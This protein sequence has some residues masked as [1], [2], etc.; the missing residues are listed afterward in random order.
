VTTTFDQLSD[1]EMLDGLSGIAVYDM[2]HTASFLVPL[3]PEW[4]LPLM[5]DSEAFETLQTEICDTLQ[6]NWENESEDTSL[7][8]C[9]IKIVE[10]VV[11]PDEFKDKPLEFFNL[12]PLERKRRDVDVTDGIDTLVIL[13][14]GSKVYA[15]VQDIADEQGAI[16]REK[17]QP[18][19]ER[20]KEHIEEV[21]NNLSWE[22]LVH[23]D[24]TEVR[25]QFAD[26]FQFNDKDDFISHKKLII[27]ADVPVRV[28][29]LSVTTDP[30]WNSGAESLQPISF[31]LLPFW[32]TLWSFCSD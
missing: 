1:D 24:T 9:S 8:T 12:Q 21:V 11:L 4:W 15:D 5:D 3:Q 14:I 20:E 10:K 27:N 13:D 23:D 32:Y 22:K 18:Y 31:L 17:L 29:V 2:N 30:V 25:E 28:A 19:F 26:I 6:K 16:I 7:W